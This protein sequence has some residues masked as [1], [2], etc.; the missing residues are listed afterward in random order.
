MSNGKSD[1]VAEAKCTVHDAGDDVHKILTEKDGAKVAI[2]HA[3]EHIENVVQKVGTVANVGSAKGVA[4][5]VPRAVELLTGGKNGNGKSG[6]LGL[7]SLLGGG[8]Q[9][10]VHGV[11]IDKQGGVHVAPQNVVAGLT[12]G[13]VDDKEKTININVIGDG[14]DAD[15]AAVAASAAN[16]GSAAASDASAAAASA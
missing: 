3:T 9:E 8:N 6:V 1:V 4:K 12:G 2:D 5:V 7:G 11:R 16:D 15:A 13:Q 14:A 10:L